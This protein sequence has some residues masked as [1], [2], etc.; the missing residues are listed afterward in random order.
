MSPPLR[1]CAGEKHDAPKKGLHFDDSAC[2][3]CGIVIARITNNTIHLH[4]FHQE[5]TDVGEFDIVYALK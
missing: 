5:H 3:A 4:K 1:R 2:V